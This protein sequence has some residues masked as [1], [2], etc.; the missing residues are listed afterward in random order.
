MLKKYL[1]DFSNENILY[2]ELY[3]DILS[4]L[5]YFKIP[6]IGNKWVQNFEEQNPNKNEKNNKKEEK[7]IKSYKKNK[8][9]N[10][11]SKSSTK[12][13]N[14]S[15]YSSINENEKWEILEND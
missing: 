9:E 6:I 10:K 5:I 2:N 12:T 4:L 1:I 7:K 8:I 14:E 3:K 13:K 15:N 11:I